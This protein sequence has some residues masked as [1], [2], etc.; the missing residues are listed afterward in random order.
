MGKAYN[1]FLD[2]EYEKL[3]CQMFEKTGC[4]LRVDS[5]DTLV[6]RE[7]LPNYSAPP[8]TM[9][10]PIRQLAVSLVSESEI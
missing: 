2:A 4:L 3:R 6:R 8:A 7:G 1:R 9:I 5:G 10:E